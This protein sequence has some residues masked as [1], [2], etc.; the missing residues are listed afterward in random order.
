MNGYSKRR[1]RTE[2]EEFSRSRG[3]SVGKEKKKRSATIF[4]LK[5]VSDKKKRKG[6]SI[7]AEE[8]EYT[9]RAGPSQKKPQAAMSGGEREP[10]KSRIIN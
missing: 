5:T 6:V 7:R 9:K 4:N 3:S 8:N 1:G 10:G 2:G